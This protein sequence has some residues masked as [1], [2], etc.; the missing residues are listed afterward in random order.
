MESKKKT[1]FYRRW[2][3][4]LLA[5]IVVGGIIPS[6]GDSSVK[7]IWNDMVLGELLPKPPAK[8]GQLYTNSAK[9]LRVTIAD[10]TDK[11]FADYVTACE[12]LGFTVDAQANFSSYSAYNAEGYKLSL[13]HYGTEGDLSINLEAPIEMSAIIW[14]TGSA[15]KQLPA[16]KSTVGKFSYEHED[17]FF[18]YVGNTSKADYTEYVTACS[19]KGFNVNYDKGEDYYS[20]D[21][22]SGWHIYLQY[23]GNSIMRV[24]ID[25]PDKEV[26]DGSV[27]IDSKPSSVDEPVVSDAAKEE[28]TPSA[29]P[30]APEKETNAIDPT[31]K[32]AMDAYE[33]FIDDYVAF[34]KKYK[35]NPTDLSLLADY[36]DYMSRYADFVKEF[37][38][39]DDKD[40]NAAET[41]YYIDVQARVSKKLLE[42]A[43]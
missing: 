7:I 38:A 13:S 27:D 11:Q 8:K 18:V 17:N 25:A 31:F 16:P 24:S 41:A 6:P 21:N 33:S 40:M 28:T 5:V 35:A 36:A 37:D 4:I 23:V 12:E 29:E 2:W 9:E 22:H 34:M 15:G 19:N 42:A 1:P 10:L 32:A 20:A 30:S 14:P 3:F 26:S 39:W 43:Q